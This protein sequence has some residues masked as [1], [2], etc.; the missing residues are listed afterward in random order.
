[1]MIKDCEECGES[2][3]CKIVTRR[4]CSNSCSSTNSNRKRGKTY[5]DFICVNC[6]KSFRDTRPKRS[7]CS[8]KCS[9]EYRNEEGNFGM[10]G[11][12]G[13]KAEFRRRL[14]K[15]VKESWTEERLE[16][17]RGKGNPMYG[18]PT[19]HSKGG[20]RED[21]GH[22]VRSTWE[23]NMC[24]VLIAQGIKYEYESRTFKLS[25]G[26]TYTPDIYLIEEDEYWEIKGQCYPVGIN[27]FLNFTEEYP[28][29]NIKMIGLE[30]YKQF[31]RIY[32]KLVLWEGRI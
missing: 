16:S 20:Y 18:I 31:K 26:S 4:F 24:R 15:G 23:A 3:E 14:K 11:Y 8:H 1:M 29:I 17:H 13:G 22:F 32:G 19:P 21:L 30:A 12:V 7:A 25:C 27:K 28:D 2:F 9:A 10:R 5:Y 6:G